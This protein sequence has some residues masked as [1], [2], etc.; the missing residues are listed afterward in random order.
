MA[1]KIPTYES[2]TLP[3]GQI[4]AQALPL[5]QTN[6]FGN[7][8]ERFGSAAAQVAGMVAKDINE[9]RVRDA[10][11]QASEAIRQILYD[12]AKGY[13]TS[14]GK[15]AVDRYRDAE[16][17]LRG[18]GDKL[19]AGLDDA[20]QKRMFSEVWQRRMD[21]A[22]NNV[23]VHAAQ[24]AKTYNDSQ[25]E[26]RAANAANDAIASFSNPTQFELH[27]NTA[28]IE[29][30]YG[31]T[32]AAAELARRKADT[33]I[34]VGVINN[35]L[36]ANQTQAAQAY[37]DAH[38]GDIDASYH[39]Q[40]VARLT[41][42]DARQKSLDLSFQLQSQYKSLDDQEAALEK[43]YKG[44]DSG[45]NAEVYDAT[46]QRLRVEAQQQKAELSDYHNMMEGHFQDWI[47][48]NPG[49]PI[50]DYTEG[51][52]WAIQNG[53]VA[54][55]QSFAKSQEAGAEKVDDPALYTDWRFKF[56]NDPL[57]AAQ[58]FQRTSS[59]LRSRLSPQHY[60]ALLTL[61][62]S[63]M[64]KD[65]KA[66]DLQ[67]Q[68]SSIVKGITGDIKAAGLSPNAKPD[69]PAAQE[70]TAYTAKLYDAI[71]D[72][73]RQKGSALTPEEGRK[74]GLRLLEEGRLQGSGAFFDDRV[75]RFQMTDDQRQYKFVTTEYA[76]IP[77]AERQQVEG[78]LRSHPTEWRRFGFAQQPGVDPVGSREW[79]YAVEQL[80]QTIKD[81]R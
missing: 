24:Q 51:Y 59:D 47:L 40:I 11:N 64:N 36:A 79:K 8:L 73:Q 15:D 30:Q 4:Q 78:W 20:V 67:R 75:R 25:A 7:A 16:A 18:L 74:V 60:E 33:A 34:N 22:L 56:S 31:K 46:K 2:S 48:K 58:E 38:K 62:T 21:S 52:A 69:S 70:W 9:G 61:S 17:S 68:T 81:K 44:G 32:G 10:D 29:A 57:N 71:D 63:S 66:L 6:V 35:M 13:L 53:R 14:T 72:A 39:D 5:E 41:A 55:M 37:F 12:P 42:G 28:L 77:T 3:Q 80:Y 1:I 27:K 49:R 23:T 76:K 43:L 45:I 65:A 50:T 19:S 54:N 26:A